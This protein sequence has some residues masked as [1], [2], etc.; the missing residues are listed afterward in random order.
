MLSIA[1]RHKYI[2]ET[3]N[4]NGFVKVSDIAKELDVTPVTI[5]KDLKNLES[6]MLLYRT[7]GSASPVN[8]YTADIDL[9][10]KEK[11]K[12][13]E[14]K[15]IAQAACKLI[16]PNDTI[17]MAA[18]S[19]V[20]A[21]AQELNFNFNLTIVS[22]SLKTSLLLNTKNNI[23][24]IQLGGFVR[25]NS[26]SV[27][28]DYSTKFFSDITCSKLFIGVDGIDIEYGITNSNI[29]EANLNKKMMEAAN[30]TIIL[31]DSSKFGKRGFGRICNL[32]KIDIIITD[33]GIHEKIAAAVEEQGIEL[34]IV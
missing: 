25:K 31:T 22:S 11:M 29:E 4:K 12:T 3:L 7:H 9:H 21:L 32:E 15:R 27:V 18:G 23:E 10:E 28:G 16:E 1:E 19:T 2:L 20:H 13:V 24:V 8:P 14:K 26:F 33:S 5:R 34:I 6:K 30:R 17:I